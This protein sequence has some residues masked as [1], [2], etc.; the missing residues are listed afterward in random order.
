MSSASILCRRLKRERG[1]VRRRVTLSLRSAEILPWFYDPPLIPSFGC[2]INPLE[3]ETSP[4]VE[5][6]GQ[7]RVS[8]LCYGG[9]TGQARVYSPV[10]TWKFDKISPSVECRYKG[11]KV[12][13]TGLL[14]PGR[15][16]R[17]PA[18]ALFPISMYIPLD[19]S[20]RGN[21]AKHESRPYTRAGK[22]AKL[23][24]SPL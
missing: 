12:L 22:L 24:V 15:R 14:R 4:S 8:S 13:T 18:T 7:P 16:E 19:G 20:T 10:E 1:I 6:K 5:K 9:K 3:L 21:R 11:E 17:R 23:R 2:V